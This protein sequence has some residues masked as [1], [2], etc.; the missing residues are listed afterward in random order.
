MAKK[1]SSFLSGVNGFTIN[2]GEFNNAERD[3]NSPGFDI[4][5]Y[6]FECRRSYKLSYF[7]RALSPQSTATLT[8]I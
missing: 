3:A 5:K 7:L 8:D 2:G 1:I 4:C 6:L